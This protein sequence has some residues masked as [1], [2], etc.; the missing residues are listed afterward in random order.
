MFHSIPGKP[1]EPEAYLS[2]TSFVVTTL[3]DWKTSRVRR[4]PVVE[5]A[6]NP[7]K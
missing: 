4:F 1:A 2:D 3:W 6:Q 7:W 5:L